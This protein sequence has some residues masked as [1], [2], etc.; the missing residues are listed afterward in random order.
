MERIHLLY[1]PDGNRRYARGQGVPLREAYELSLDKIISFAGWFFD[2][3][4]AGELSIHALDRYNLRR[5]SEEIGPLKRTIVSG[6]QKICDSRV[7]NDKGLTVRVVGRLSDLF[8]DEEREREAEL[9]KTL[10][11]QIPTDRKLNLL[12]SYDPDEELQKA[13]QKCERDGV[14]V[15]FRNLS[16]RW[17]IS[18]VSML[19]RTSQLSNSIRISAYFPGI[20]QAKLISIQTSPQ[21]LTKGEFNRI[22]DLYHSLT[23]TTN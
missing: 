17:S 7:V 22:M 16:E 3:E 15:T 6:I 2:Y 10:A 4:Q 23:K 19:L 14:P 12:V 9:Q 21:E 1:Q 20:E 13:S 18:P 5:S 11:K 8:S